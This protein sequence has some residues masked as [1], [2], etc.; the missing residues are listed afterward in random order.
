MA[1]AQDHGAMAMHQCGEGIFI[2]SANEALEQVAVG[3]SAAIVGG[4]EMPQVLEE[5]GERSFGH[6][7]GSPPLVLP[8]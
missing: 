3:G 5:V 1:D 6:W 7:R 2:S 8:Y 4:I